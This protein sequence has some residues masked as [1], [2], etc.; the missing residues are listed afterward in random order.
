MSVAYV[1]N[2]YRIKMVKCIK[3][4]ENQ[5]WKFTFYNKNAL[6]YENIV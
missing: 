5:E 2:T 1:D 3:N 6:Y 4:D